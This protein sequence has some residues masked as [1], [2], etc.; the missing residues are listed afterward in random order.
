[1]TS[2]QDLT[3]ENVIAV[4]LDCLI[5]YANNP[6]VNDHAV[7]RMA[8]MIRQHGFRVPV[9]VRT[10]NDDPDKFDLVDGHLRLKAALALGMETLPAVVVDDMS[11]EQVRAFRVS[12]NR[13]AELADWD[14]S[15]LAAEFE[16][17]QPTFK[18]NLSALTGFD[19]VALKA[20][21]RDMSTPK[22]KPDAGPT[23]AEPVSKAADRKRAT[24]DT[25]T[26]ELTFTMTA[27]E[28]DEAMKGIETL[29][30]SRA[31]IPTNTQALLTCIREAVAMDAAA[32][33]RRRRT[34]E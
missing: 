32:K 7:D 24:R 10:N 4:P 11:E 25:D 29:R 34:R 14:M 31:D 27:A 5:P 9:L 12:V 22:I 23:R 13:A 26:V 3:E 18:D 1:M 17:I 20:M 2:A 33:P 6:R 16:A 19:D 21:A 15:K 8:D 30:A 28:R